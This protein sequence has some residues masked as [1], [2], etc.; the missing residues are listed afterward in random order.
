MALITSDC[1]RPSGVSMAVEGPVNHVHSDG[2][3]TALNVAEYLFYSLFILECV[4]KNIAWGFYFNEGAYLKE[5][6]NVFDF[7]VVIVTTIDMLLR[8]LAVDAQWVQAI[9]LMRTLRLVRL[10][11]KID[12]MAVMAKA[13]V[14]C[15]PS[16]SAIM[17]LL[18]GNIVSV[19]TRVVLGQWDYRD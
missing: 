17:A 4:L 15:L 5:P 3:A 7:T 9:R 13:I 18:L 19:P 16:V 11:E 14:K 1:V 2:V 8:L 10:L 12:G 6:T